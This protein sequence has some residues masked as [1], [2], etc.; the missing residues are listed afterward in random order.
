MKPERVNFHIIRA[1]PDPDRGETINVG[2][3]LTN[4]EDAVLSLDF[5]NSWQRLQVLDPNITKDGY[6]SLVGWLSQSSANSDVAQLSEI[7]E[8]ARLS[9]TFDLTKGR[10]V[11]FKGSP[12]EEVK[13]WLMKRFVDQ[14]GLVRVRPSIRSS[15]L[16]GDIHGWLS[17]K[18]LVSRE[19]S[20]VSNKLIQDFVLDEDAQA[21]A[22]FVGKNGAWHVFETL[23]L[24]VGARTLKEKHLEAGFKAWKLGRSE[25]ILRS[26]DD[27]EVKRFVIYASS[28]ST[29]EP[30]MQKVVDQCLNILRSSADKLLDYESSGD[31]QLVEQEMAKAVSAPVT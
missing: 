26:K 19:P 7:A 27:I 4:N 12:I 23:D 30:T 17:K 3:I 13:D 21:S 15:R 16:K 5:S 28:K 9:G 10:E 1:I 25:E 6:S 2:L 8:N 14:P 20:E 29:P 22:D 24:R 11:T 18:R 31:R